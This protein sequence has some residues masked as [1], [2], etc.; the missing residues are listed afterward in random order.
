MCRP[1]GADDSE[2]GAERAEARD[3]PEVCGCEERE[4]RPGA[5]AFAVHGC[6]IAAK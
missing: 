4:L 3:R 6:V 1:R 5:G 2:E